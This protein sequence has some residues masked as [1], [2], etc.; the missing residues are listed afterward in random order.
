MKQQFISIKILLLAVLIN[1]MAFAQAIK[2]ELASKLQSNMDAVWKEAEAD[3]SSN[4]IPDKWK[5][6]SG[7]VIAQ[8][9]KFVFDKGSGV[10]KLNV[11]ETTH[12]KIKLLDKDGVNSYSEFYFR[13]GHENDGF[14]LHIIKADGT[15]DTMS[16]LTAV[17]VED[18]DDVPGTFTPYFGK[19][20]HY[21]K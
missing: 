16:L 9:I 19:T 20:K 3:F 4:Q 21:K 1:T 15:V 5:G 18:N 8:K 14:A 13:R 12:R 7:V 6:Y 11:Y 10:D 17:L 2:E